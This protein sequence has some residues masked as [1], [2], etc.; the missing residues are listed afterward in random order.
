MQA[1]PR[2]CVERRQVV[3]P[4]SC[5]GPAESFRVEL[6][7][8]LL[9]SL[10]YLELYRGEAYRVLGSLR[11]S[12]RDLTEVRG[13]RPADLPTHRRR[14][15]VPSPP[16]RLANVSADRYHSVTMGE[17]GGV[18]VAGMQP[19]ERRLALPGDPRGVEKPP[20]A[21]AR[22]EGTTSSGGAALPAAVGERAAVA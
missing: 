8:A 10:A 20:E 5:V 3:R 12:A 2:S 4:A 21:P 16:R 22:G 1:G 19:R 7:F 15:A 18:A 9:C 14:R 6:H 11:P 17:S 13:S